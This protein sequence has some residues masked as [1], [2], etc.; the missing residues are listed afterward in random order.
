M[1]RHALRQLQRR[2]IGQ[3]TGL[4]LGQRE[5]DMLRRQDH[6]AGQRQLETAADCHAVQRC[7]DRLVQPRQLL[8]PPKPPMP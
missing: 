8:Q 7:N 1:V 6:V 5:T 3:R 2:R 4:D